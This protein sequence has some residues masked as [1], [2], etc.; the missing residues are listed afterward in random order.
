MPLDNLTWICPV[1]L[2]GYV[3]PAC[4]LDAKYREMPEGFWTLAYLIG[5]PVTALLYL[6]GLYPFEALVV[7]LL[8]VC[9]WLLMLCFGVFQGADFMY[10]TAISMFFVT[11]PVSGQSLM[12][13]PF[14]I[15]LVAS[16]VIFAGW[17]QALKY[18][19]VKPLLGWFESK[20]LPGFPAMFPISFALILTA[21]LA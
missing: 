11:N 21:V 9:A 8:A 20:N 19:D 14:A 6:D 2:L 5:I 13:V 15:F 4:Y 7:S 17:Y 10:L 3:A 16:V 18:F 1:I 12:V